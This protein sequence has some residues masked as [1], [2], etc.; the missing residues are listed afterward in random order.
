MNRSRPRGRRPRVALPV[1]VSV[2]ALALWSP[3]PLFAQSL[4]AEQALP[5]SRVRRF[6]G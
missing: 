5:K 1:T 4:T 2:L 6:M 3:G